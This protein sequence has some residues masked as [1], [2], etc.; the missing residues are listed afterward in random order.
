MELRTMNN[1]LFSFI[2]AS[3][4]FVLVG[5]AQTHADL[6]SYYSFDTGQYNSTHAFDEMG[7]FNA[8][9]SS[10][11]TV[12]NGQTG[13]VGQATNVSA[14]YYTTSSTIFSGASSNYTVSFWFKQSATNR[15]YPVATAGGNATTCG[16]DWRD[17]AQAGYWY[18]GGIT[19]TDATAS[20]IDGNT[21]HYV[22]L[23]RYANGTYQS[24]YNG[25]L[26]GSANN[27]AAC[28]NSGGTLAFFRLQATTFGPYNTFLDEVAVF[29]QTLNSSQIS[30]LFNSGSGT[31]KDGALTCAG[32]TNNFTITL[33]DEYNGSTINTFNATVNG[34]LYTTTT[35]SIT[36]N[37]SLGA[38]NNTVNITINAQNYFDVSYTN[39]NAITNLAAT[40]YQAV[41]RF[42]AEQFITLNNITSF[43]VTAPNGKNS[44]SSPPSLNLA[45]GTYGITFNK[46][47]YFSSNQ[48]FTIAALSNQTYNFTDIYNILLNITAVN[49]INGSSVNSF[50]VNITSGSY[51]FNV[52]NAS[53]TNGTIFQRWIN[54]TNMNI[55]LYNST[56]IA[57]ASILTNTSNYTAPAQVNISITSAT[58]NSIGFFFFDEVSGA[59]LNNTTVSAYITSSVYSVNF[60][61]TNGTSYQDLLVPATYTI[62]YSA[63]GYNQREYIYE[64]VNQSATTLYLYLINDTDDTIVLAT[65]FDTVGRRVQGANIYSD[66]KNLSGTNYYTVE[67]CTTNALGQCLLH[68]DL[69][70]TT[71]QFRIEYNGVFVFNSQD[72]KVSQTAISFT[73]VTSNSTLQTI[74]GL[75]YFEG[76]LNYSNASSTFTYS[77]N[78]TDD[79]FD[80]VC[81]KTVIRTDNSY[82]NNNS[83]C[84]TS[85]SASLTLV[86]NSSVGDEWTGMAYGVT[87]LGTVYQLD[88]LSV[89]VDLFLTRFGKTGLYYFG[90]LLVGAM[91]FSALIHPIFPPLLGGV[92]IWVMN[93]LGFIGVGTAGVLS[94]LAVVI[95]IILI[96][97][98][99]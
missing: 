30:C 59:L 60:T 35:G 89:V 18:Q 51:S 27:V 86:I 5:V 42:N 7:R 95:I 4:L 34:T 39:Y 46:T 88:S 33:T 65:I 79:I 47:G 36:T 31:S 21:W 61:T 50:S 38:T 55:T 24:Y 11:T 72:T 57:T 52:T 8:T 23:T 48:T 14:S 78:D 26:F 73:I 6:Q 75:G 99:T 66:K 54:D 9:A 80:Y 44:N 1:K 12:Q 81:L 64:L 94:L 49:A 68:V 20:H 16:Y 70:E 15:V 29:N 19:I 77:F 63:T 28:D 2:I 84:S 41:A 45:A 53:T 74:Y 10:S 91:M 58:I 69:Y 98:R 76:D 82:T 25:T 71:Y 56:E 67:T 83:N 92:T 13:K 62:T 90:F 37:L 93:A 96:N 32:L 87:S 17:G 3:A 40:A 43:T 97:K 22:T 85:D